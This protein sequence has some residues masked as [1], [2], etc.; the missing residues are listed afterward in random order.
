MKPS[1]ARPVAKRARVVGS[2]IL[3]AEPPNVFMLAEKTSDDPRLVCRNSRID[4]KLKSAPE[5]EL[6]RLSSL[7]KDLLPN[8]LMVVETSI[9]PIVEALEIPTL[10]NPNAPVS[11]ETETAKSGG[12]SVPYVPLRAVPSAV[13]VKPPTVYVIELGGTSKPYSPVMDEFGTPSV[14]EFA[15]S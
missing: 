2:V 7:K 4:P 12:T 11:S 10:S 5:N 13:K 9:V 3:S 15:G 6:G 1:P 8:S 14:V